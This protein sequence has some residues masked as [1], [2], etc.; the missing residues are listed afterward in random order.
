MTTNAQVAHR[1]AQSLLQLAVEKGSLEE[2]R[3]DMNLLSVTAAENRALRLLLTSPIVT[4][5]KKL[6]TLKAVFG[7]YFSALT[8]SFITLLCKKG[9]E[10]DLVGIAHAFEKQYNTRMGIAVAQVTT[11]TPITE[12]L[13]T[14]FSN[15]VAKETGS[16]VQLQ[17]QVDPS[18]LG[19]FR[20]QMGDRQI[21]S[22]VKAKLAALRL[23]LI[24]NTYIS[25]L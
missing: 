2:V 16:K 11:A 24:D 7:Q 23:K 4:G 12:E 14:K 20:L 15:L 9:R 8:S 13:R 22:T 10:A 17:E 6:N 5:E 25:K 3:A 1:Y 19:G 18:I 21:D